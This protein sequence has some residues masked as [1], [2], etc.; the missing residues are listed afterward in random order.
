MLTVL[1]RRGVEMAHDGECKETQDV[2]ICPPILT[3][4]CGADNITYPS[5]CEMDCK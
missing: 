1:W 4:V 2:C 3:P 5:Q